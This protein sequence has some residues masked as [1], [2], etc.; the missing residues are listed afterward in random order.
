[1]EHYRIMYIWKTIT[2][3]VPNFGLIL[4]TNFRRG[5]MVNIRSYKSNIPTQAKNLIDQFLEVHGGRLFNLLPV[6]L[7]IFEGTVGTI[8]WSTIRFYDKFN[9]SFLQQ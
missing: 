5:H 1:M 2:E 9:I 8:I 7:R 6:D 4:D 3:K